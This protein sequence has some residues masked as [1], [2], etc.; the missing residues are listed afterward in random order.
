MSESHPLMWT[1]NVEDGRR[2]AEGL[3]RMIYK[4]KDGRN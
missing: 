2:A 4:G 3:M 1:F